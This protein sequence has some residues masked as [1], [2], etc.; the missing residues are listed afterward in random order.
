MCW[1][2]LQPCLLQ[3]QQSQVW[4]Y[5]VYSQDAGLSPPSGH[6]G[7]PLLLPTT[8]PTSPPGSSRLCPPPPT[9][10]LSRQQPRLLARPA[11]A[12]S[13]WPRPAEL[14]SLE[15]HTAVLE[16]LPQPDRLCLQMM[17]VTAFRFPEHRRDSSTLFWPCGIPSGSQL[18]GEAHFGWFWATAVWLHS[19]R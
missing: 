11:P 17:L 7:T 18:P 9:W 1:L 8:A 14:L 12:L 4:L 3:S 15:L 10:P 16:G 19:G 6:A 5:S 2:S 13:S